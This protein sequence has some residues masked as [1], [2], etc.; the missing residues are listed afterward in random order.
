MKFVP[1]GKSGE[2]VPCRHIPLTSGGDTL[3]ELDRGGTE[4]EIQEARANW[5]QKEI[6]KM[7]SADKSGSPAT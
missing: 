4:Q 7:E 3:L 2:K 5:L 1:V 6:A